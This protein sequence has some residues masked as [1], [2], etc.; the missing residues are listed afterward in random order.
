LEEG[1]REGGGWFLGV[2][3]GLYPFSK[4]NFQDFSRTFPGLRLIFPGI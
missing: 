1:R 3:Q 2:A 4:T